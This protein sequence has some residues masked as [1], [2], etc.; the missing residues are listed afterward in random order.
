[1]LLVEGTLKG[2][3]YGADGGLAKADELIEKFKLGSFFT[4]KQSFEVRLGKSHR[5]K[6]PAHDNM[7]MVGNHTE[8]TYFSAV[9]DGDQFTLRYY[10]TVGTIPRKGI[11]EKRYKPMR[12]GLSSSTFLNKERDKEKCLFLILHPSCEQSPL[13]KNGG[14]IGWSIVDRQAESKKALEAE[15]L[16]GQVSALVWGADQDTLR[17]KA[18]GIKVLDALSENK[19]TYLQVRDAANSDI[20]SIK[21]DL[22]RIAKKYPQ[23]FLEQWNDAGNDIFGILQGAV[24]GGII[25]SRVT[26][27]GNTTWKWKAGINDGMEITTVSKLTDPM[28]GLVAWCAE[29]DFPEISRIISRASGTGLSEERLSAVMAETF[30][31]K[32]IDMTL[33][34]LVNYGKS[35]QGQGNAIYFDAVGK[36]VIL[37]DGGYEPIGEPLLTVK[38][39]ALWSNELTIA[40]EDKTLAK[41]L[42]KH[43]E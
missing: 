37:V 12:I 8:S 16:N 24:S 39:K 27:M 23:Q 25:E 11:P 5:V 1:M 3:D 10:E 6:S 36:K 4:G 22:I 40:L 31:K 28:T 34:E 35:R 42:R 9:H 2:R 33:E 7:E 38:D 21:I 18:H 15:K 26:S 17:R 32:P 30:G 20:D 13:R 14:K 19:G 43:L 41:R 29:N